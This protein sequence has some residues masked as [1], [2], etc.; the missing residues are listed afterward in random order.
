VATEFQRARDAIFR[1]H[2]SFMRSSLVALHPNLPPA[3]IGKAMLREQQLGATYEQRAAR[4]L[5]LGIG[6]VTTA[7][8]L[9]PAQRRAAITKVLEAERRYLQL[10]MA[11]ASHR[12]I[13][14]SDLARLEAEGEQLGVWTLDPTKRT[15]TPDCL[16][17]ANK[18]WPLSLLRQYGPQTRHAGCGCRVRSIAEARAMGVPVG[19]GR[20]TSARERLL[21][22]AGTEP[23]VTELVERVAW[24]VEHG[25]VDSA[26]DGIA[27][28]TRLRGLLALILESIKVPIRPGLHWNEALH[29]R[30]PGGRFIHVYGSVDPSL[31]PH[32]QRF[33]RATAAGDPDAMDAHYEELYKAARK[34][35]SAAHGAQRKARQGT[36]RYDA[37]TKARRAAEKDM[38]TIARVRAA[39][40]N[41]SGTRVPVGTTAPIGTRRV[42]VPAIP[43]EP[44]ALLVKPWAPGNTFRWHLNPAD[45]GDGGRSLALMRRHKDF[46]VRDQADG[47]VLITTRGRMNAHAALLRAR[48]LEAS[49]PQLRRSR[50]TAPRKP[51]AD[52]RPLD[53][54]VPADRDMSV[55]YRNVSKGQI[56]DT[57]EAAIRDVR[58]RLVELGMADPSDAGF[59][60]PTAG[61][62]DT[63]IDWVIG[64]RA[65]EVKTH[66]WRGST[67]GSETPRPKIGLDSSSL[68]S[69]DIADLNAK[70][71]KGKGPL[72]PALVQI[73]TDLDN[74]V[75]HVFVYDYPRGKPITAV[76]VPSDMFADLAAGKLRPGEQRRPRGANAPTTYVGTFKLR[77]NPLRD[78]AGHRLKREELH[79]RAAH[80][81]TK[82]N[83]I[84]LGGPADVGPRGEGVTP[85]PPVQRAVRSA[86]PKEPN[87]R[88]NRAFVKDLR[89]YAAGKLKDPDTGRPMGQR[90]L[91]AKHGITQPRVSQML[92]ELGL[93]KPG[94]GRSPATRR[95]SRRR[96]TTR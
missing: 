88:S 94:R 51:F 23:D 95:R 39:A 5:R 26:L 10:R 37:A 78:K 18:A 17:M 69:G 73:F 14:E 1:A 28:D 22:E 62:A 30:G 76:R 6:K 48:S 8:G 75:A 20:F 4:R 47:S 46:T 7:R 38:R 36:K 93:R 81:S 43:H 55:T 83:P 80:V 77:V 45:I 52:D 89:L 82:T 60:W 34:R 33:L 9:T 31:R 87:L 86:A 29:P 21:Q 61:R 13:V 59:F 67:P 27:G 64:N 11:R 42:P 58:D 3:A 70:H 15:H 90:A 44:G 50:A 74:N 54:D 56:G 65:M 25:S 84:K 68:K 12:M 32:L 72:R 85:P 53:L 66:A 19:R 24:A 49:L 91:A 2:R 71:R 63:P 35:M 92:D 57:G 40:I 41:P 96:T 16:T 79:A